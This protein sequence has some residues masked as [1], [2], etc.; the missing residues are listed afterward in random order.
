MHPLRP[1][2][3]ARKTEILGDLWKATR[4]GHTLRVQVRTQPAGWQV[5]AF[6]GLE[7]HRSVLLGSEVEVFST[8]DEWRAEAV[9]KGWTIEPSAIPG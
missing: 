4:K 7:I 1:Y 6:V 3:P 2:N 8:S 5:L 9:A